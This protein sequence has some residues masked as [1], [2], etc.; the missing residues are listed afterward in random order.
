M[1]QQATA[2]EPTRYSLTGPERCL[3]YRLGLEA[4]L[5]ANEIRTLTVR[6]FDLQ[7]RTITIRSENAKNRTEAVLPLR[8]DF[9]ETLR[10]HLAGKLPGAQAFKLTD[11]PARMFYADCEAAGIDYQDQGSGKLDFHSTRHSFATALAAANVP[12]KVA[13]DLL[14]HGDIRL[15]MNVYSHSFIGQLSDGVNRLPDFAGPGSEQRKRPAP[16]TSTA[17]RIPGIKGHSSNRPRFRPY[18]VQNIVKVWTVLESGK[19]TDKRKN[20][21]SER[22]SLFF[23]QKRGFFKR[24][25]RDSNPQPSD[26]QSDTLTN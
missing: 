23:T 1:T 17:W 4:G 11:K 5:R 9:A 25:R 20:P 14:R 6:D 10:G 22:K 8:D 16:M 3:V 19:K 2:T 18:R 24:G 7:G 26:R 12:P 13:Q 21:V 15:T